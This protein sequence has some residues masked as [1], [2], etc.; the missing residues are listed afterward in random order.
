MELIVLSNPETI[1][2]EAKIINQ[3]FE[4]GMTRF[5]LRKPGWSGNQCMDLLKDLDPAF[6][7]AIAL[8]QHHYLTNDLNTKR[9]HFTENHR[10]NTSKETLINQNLS[11]F[12]CSTSVHQLAEIH[13]LNAFDYVFF[14][15]VFHSISKPGYQSKLEKG[16]VL[17]KVNSLQ[18]VIALGGIDEHNLNQIRQMKFDGAAVLGAIWKNPEQ[19]VTIFKKLNDLTKSY[20]E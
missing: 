13:S 6:H 11:G 3:L 4:A 19:A 17:K 5:H 8:H 18:K 9:L 12:L 14:S 16:F 7:P 1:A 20:K 2:N 10:F 15:P